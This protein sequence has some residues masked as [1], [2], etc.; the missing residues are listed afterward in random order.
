MKIRAKF[1]A[2]L[3]FTAAMPLSHALACEGDIVGNWE[4]RPAAS[5]AG[6]EKIESFRINSATGMLGVCGSDR[7]WDSEFTNENDVL[8]F[9]FARRMRIL[10]LGEQGVYS[11][12]IW[13]ADHNGVKSEYRVTA[14]Y[15]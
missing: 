9:G 14:K 6:F 13:I 4:K 12:E 2:G 10:K 3:V 15:E 1:L 7:V 8:K 11:T 5:D